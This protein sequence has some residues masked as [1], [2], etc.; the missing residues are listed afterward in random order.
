MAFETL[1]LTKFDIVISVTSEAAKGVITPPHTRHICICLTPTRYLYSGYD[2]YIKDRWFEAVARP[3]LWYL[4]LWDKVAAARPDTYVA[5]SKTVKSRIQNIYGR[6]AQLLYPPI[7]IKKSQ[8][9]T[10]QK[11]YFLVVS[12]MVG[13]KR[14]DLAI[15]AANKL[16][17]PLKIVGEGRLEKELRDIAGPTIEFEGFV[18]ESKLI[19]LYTDAKALIFPGNEDLG[20]TMIEAQA[21]GTPVIALRKGGATEVVKEGVTGEFFEDQTVDSLA[22]AM[23]KFERAKYNN[24]KCIENGTRFS[25]EKFKA[26]LIEL[27]KDS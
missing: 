18:T 20:L 19:K 2:E 11:D 16:H 14:I 6:Q 13:Y 22:G 27:L 3:V 21:C 17:V 26:D 9:D 10:S 7:H 15:H 12:R 25:F 4:K 8:Q 5:I 23:E 1:D 24:K